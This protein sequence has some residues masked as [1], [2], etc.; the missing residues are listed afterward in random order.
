MVQEIALVAAL[1][2]YNV[3]GKD[4]DIPWRCKDDLKFFQKLTKGHIVIMGRKTWDSLPVKP[5]KKRLNIVVTRGNDL[6][7]CVAHDESFDDDTAISVIHAD[8]AYELALKT[9]KNVQRTYPEKK[10]FVIGGS[11]AYNYFLPHA[12][13]LY[14]TFVNYSG[15]GDTYFPEYNH[16]HWYVEDVNVGYPDENNDHSFITQRLYKKKA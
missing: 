13:E 6:W 12:S 3:I 5:L 1:G 10:I 7:G 11:S 4:G 8:N 14:L 9:A 16:R 2:H 15:G